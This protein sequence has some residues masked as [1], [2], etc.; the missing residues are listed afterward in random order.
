M[1]SMRERMD[2]AGDLRSP[3]QQR[4]ELIV[5]PYFRDG[6]SGGVLL[7]PHSKQ[8]EFLADVVMQLSG[9]MST[10]LLLCFNQAAAQ[11]GQCVFRSL[12]VGNVYSRTNVA[13]E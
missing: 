8:R 4:L 7:Q 6:E 2:I 5:E 11:A 13:G 12:T 1:Q 10:L 9:D 3:L